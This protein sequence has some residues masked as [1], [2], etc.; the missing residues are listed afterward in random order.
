MNIELIEKTGYAEIIYL[1]IYVFGGIVL[2]LLAR[3]LTSRLKARLRGQDTIGVGAKLL[4]GVDGALPLWIMFSGLYFGITEI[5]ADSL[6]DQGQPGRYISTIESLYVASSICIAVY[7]LI[8]IQGHFIT[9]LSSKVG[10]DTDQA[11]VVNSLAPLASQ[12]FRLLIVVMGFLIILDQ[13]GISIAPLVAGLGIGGLAVALALQGILTNFFAGLTVMTD[14]TI[15]VGDY[16]ELDGGVL[17]LVEMIGWR[18]T[19]IRLLSDNM[20]VIPNNKLADNIA[21]NY[22]HPRG[23]MSVYVQVGVSYFSNL[24]HVEEVTIEVANQVLDKVE[25]G[26]KGFEPSVWY[27]EFADS[28]INF[29]VV[30]RSHDY[31]SSWKVKH[32]FVKELFDRYDKEG[33]EISF[34]ANNIFLRNT[35]S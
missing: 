3:L 35:D 10:R 11:K 34:P 8:R 24:E 13:L 19:R 2:A 29:W 4:D 9:W 20:L 27:T 5:Y 25:G 16:I 32:M 23:E 15:R 1:S 6:Y 22:S 33:I 21:T 17:G 14:G 7:A 28:N 30:L 26:V 12:I 18:T 31:I